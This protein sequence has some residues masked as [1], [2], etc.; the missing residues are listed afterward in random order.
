MSKELCWI[1]N[2]WVN[3]I[4]LMNY[5]DYYGSIEYSAE[6]EVFFGKIEFINDLVTFEATRVDEL[7]KAFKESVEHYI[8]KRLKADLMSGLNLSFIKKLHLLH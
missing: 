8:R 2:R 6:D 4:N 5:K 3:M 1:S 7:K